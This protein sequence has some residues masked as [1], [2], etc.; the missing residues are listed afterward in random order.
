MRPGT[1]S[2]E[3]EQACTRT[4]TLRVVTRSL[5][6][7]Q[8]RASENCIAQPQ[9]GC[10]GANDGR[11]VGPQ[12]VDI[13]AFRGAKAMDLRPRALEEFRALPS[14]KFS[15]AGPLRPK[16]RNPAR[17]GCMTANSVTP[18]VVGPITIGVSAVIARA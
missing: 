16:L 3:L 18:S 6:P 13:S 1:H 7:G 15:M 14:S 9:G 12:T 8:F 17:P 11:D 10:R 5:I 2:P 4:A